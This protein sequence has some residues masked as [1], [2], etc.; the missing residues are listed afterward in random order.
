MLK[1]GLSLAS[2][3]VLLVGV[4]QC[5]SDS[6]FMFTQEVEQTPCECE[7]TSTFPASESLEGF[8]YHVNIPL[9]EGYTILCFHSTDFYAFPSADDVPK[10]K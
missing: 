1:R 3:T 7:T 4:G 8:G 9:R 2:V 5:S 10:Q 6:E